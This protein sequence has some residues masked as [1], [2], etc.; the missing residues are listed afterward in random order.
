M[1]PFMQGTTHGLAFAVQGHAPAPAVGSAQWRRQQQQRQRQQ[2]QLQQR[3][4]QVTMLTRF[5]GHHLVDMEADWH[6]HRDRVLVPCV[7]TI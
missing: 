1:L 2:S 7:R 3:A 5:F 6:I 4:E